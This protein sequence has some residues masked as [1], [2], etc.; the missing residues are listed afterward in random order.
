M[1][2]YWEAV[3]DKFESTFRDIGTLTCGC[4]KKA[5]PNTFK[6]AAKVAKIFSAKAAGRSV[7]S[8][9]HNK[10]SLTLLIDALGSILKLLPGV[11][12]GISI[13]AM[14]RI[15]PFAKLLSVILDAIINFKLPRNKEF[16]A[17]LFDVTKEILVVLVK[18]AIISAVLLLSTGTGMGPYVGCILLVLGRTYGTLFNAEKYDFIEDA[19]EEIFDYTDLPTK[20]AARILWQSGVMFKAV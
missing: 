3:F 5:V 18:S 11:V 10:F 1:D 8:N 20:V 17:F 9:K 14:Q 13:V 15:A 16:A 4:S 19:V 2:S 7:F 6:S 12:C